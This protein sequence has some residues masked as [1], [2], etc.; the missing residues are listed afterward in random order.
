MGPNPFLW[1]LL[2]S[3]LGATGEVTE[4]SETPT[5]SALEGWHGVGGWRK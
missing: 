1:L 3:L 2:R 4:P 5:F